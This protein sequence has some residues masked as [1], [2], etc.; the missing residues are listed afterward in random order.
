M[1]VG[2]P[3]GVKGY[4]LYDLES[5]QFFISRDVVFHENLFSFHGVPHA[6]STSDPFSKLVLPTPQ[7]Y[8]FHESSTDPILATTDPTH[9]VDMPTVADIPLDNAT[10]PLPLRRSSWQIDPLVSS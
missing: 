7:P 5:R 2:H 4:K 3:V 8:M 1:F 10:N 6:T 9:A